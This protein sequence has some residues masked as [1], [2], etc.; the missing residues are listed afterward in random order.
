MSL[1]QIVKNLMK[2]A[3]Y[4]IIIQDSNYL[5]SEN[6]WYFQESQPKNGNLYEF[7]AVYSY[8]EDPADDTFKYKTVL[9]YE[10]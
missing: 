5:W 4:K 9:E 1:R 3:G 8:A 2:I 6:A 7:E 10:P